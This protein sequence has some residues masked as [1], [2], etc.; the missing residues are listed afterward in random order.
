MIGQ[1]L[2]HFLRAAGHTVKHFV[3]KD[4]PDWSYEICWDPE[5]GIMDDFSDVNVIVH[6]AGESISSAIRWDQ[7]KNRIRRSRI[8]STQAIVT[9][10]KEMDHKAHTFICASGVGI[11]PSSNQ[12]MTENGPVGDRFLARVVTDWEKACEPIADSIRVLNARFG[13]VLH[14]SGGVVKRL[15]PLMKLGALGRFGSGEQFTSWVSLDDVVRVLYFMMANKDLVGPVNVVSPQPQPQYEWI[16]EWASAVYRPAFAP[17]PETIVSNIMG[18]MGEELLLQSLRVVPKKID[19]C[20]ISVSNNLYDRSLSFLSIMI[21]TVYDQI[22]PYQTT[23]KSH[24]LYQSIQSIEHL[25][26][27]M[28]YHIYS[29]WDFMNLL[30]TL[31][32]TF[33]CTSI[34]W[35][36]TEKVL[37]MRDLLMKLF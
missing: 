30:K 6:L 22:A 3:R 27:F 35:R 16:K 9:Q 15:N 7:Q 13:T 17:L 18:E 20:S 21:Q 11:Y 31:Q 2:T 37:R 23:L 25:M 19:G 26:T 34:P 14:P 8:R 28:S 36:P 32:T 1:Q 5:V 33:T 24:C 29:V 12:P 4:R 10:L